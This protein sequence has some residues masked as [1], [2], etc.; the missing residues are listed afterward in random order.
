MEAAPRNRR[1]LTLAGQEG[2]G[3]LPPAEPVLFDLLQITEHGIQEVLRI[4]F[5]HQ[6]FPGNGPR[7]VERF[8]VLLRR[9]LGKL[10]PVPEHH[11]DR[12]VIFFLNGF[13]EPIEMLGTQLL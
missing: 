6:V 13:H 12:A 2:K 10:D 3:G 9:Q 1:A 4:K 7:L 5:S 8:Q 11:L